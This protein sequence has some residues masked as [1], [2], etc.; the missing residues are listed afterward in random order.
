MKGPYPDSFL[1]IHVLSYITT[2]FYFPF[3]SPYLF[4][5]LLLPLFPFSF[6]FLFSYVSPF[7]LSLSS[8]VF[9]LLFVLPLFSFF[10][11]PF[12]SYALTSLCLPFLLYYFFYSFLRFLLFLSFLFTDTVPSLSSFPLSFSFFLLLLLSFRSLPFSFF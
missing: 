10:P 2:F 6:H 4:L 3:L 7:L 12:L 11:F 8:S 9:L 1:T 5:L